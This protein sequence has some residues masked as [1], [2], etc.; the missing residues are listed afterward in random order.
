MGEGFSVQCQ[1]CDYSKEFMLGVGMAYGSLENVFNNIHHTRRAKILDLLNNHELP[2][3][4][5]DY[6]RNPLYEHLLYSCSKCHELYE[7]FYVKILFGDEG[8][9]ETY[10]TV[11]SCGKCKEPL[12]KA[13]EKKKDIEK[14]KCPSC[15]AKK[16]KKK[17]QFFWD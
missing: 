2:V 10:E 17:N 4:I 15:G 12:S 3:Y 1:V 11:F 13:S 16:L 8:Q 7:R 9:E 6:T 14:R 5:D